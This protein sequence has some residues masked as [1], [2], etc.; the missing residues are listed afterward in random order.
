L[1]RPFTSTILLLVALLTAE[2]T[3]ARDASVDYEKAVQ[4][5]A[6]DK[7]DEAYINLKNALQEDP[8][9]LSARLLLAEVYFNSG[10]IAGAQRESEEALLLGAD[11]NLVLPIY[12]QSLILQEKVDQLFEI[13]RSADSFTPASQFEWALLKGQGYL[14]RNE[15]D[16]A[17]AQFEKATTILPE[18][19]RSDNTIAAIYLSRNMDAD[20]RKLVD[21]SL[22]LDPKN[23]KTWQLSGELEFKAK[24]YDQALKYFQRGYELDPEDLRIQRSLAQIYLQLG[25]RGK[26]EE[27]LKR[28][29]DVSPDDPAAT[30]ISAL[31]LIGDG[32]VEL[33]DSMLGNLSSMLSQ[34]DEGKR[35]S[36]ETMLFIRASAEYIQGNDASAIGLFNT[37]LLHN[38]GNIS[39]V[40]ILADLYLRNGDS[41]RATELLSSRVTEVSADLGLSIQLLNLYIKSGNT[42][43]A[44]ELLATLKN[45]GAGN[46]P[47][48]V[49]A[50]A[51]LL[52]LKGQPADALHLMDAQQFEGKLP[53]G[54]DLLRGVLQ[55]E[56]GKNAEAQHGVEQLIAA[57]PNIVRINNFAAA[58]YLALDKLPEANTYIDKALQ[59]EPKNVDARFNRAMWYKKSGELDN[60]TKTLK[61]L[62]E[63]QPSHTKALLL[64]ARIL[65]LQHKYDEAIDWSDKVYAYDKT[66]RTPGE[67]QIEIYSQAGNWE[68]AKEVAQRLVREDPLNTDY[69]VQLATIAMKTEDQELAQNTLSRLYPLWKRDPDKLRQLAEMQARFHN[70]VAARK[71]LLQALKLDKDDYL[72]QLDIARLDLAEGNYDTAQK[73]AEGLKHEFGERSDSSQV[74]GEIAFA[75]QQPDVARQHFLDAFRLNN[76]NTEA[77]IRLYELSAKGPG[78]KA[79]TDTMESTLKKASLPVV[80]VRLMADSYLSQGKTAKAAVYYEKLLGLE[81]LASDP[82]I[83]NNLANI[84]AKDDLAK[85]LTTAKKGLEASGEQSYALLD[86]VGW[87]LARQGENEQA[88]SYLRKSYTKNSTDPEIRYHLGAT[89]LALGRTAEAKKE[90]RAALDS[91]QQ[92][93]GRDDAEKL[94]ASATQ[95]ASASR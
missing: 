39:A 43:R 22:A 72:V 1:I 10:D 89:L 59:L 20:A 34:F 9:L 26:A 4:A 55:L 14:L 8:N 75:R 58:T 53:Q 92:F 12:G 48:L 29:L 51:E 62:V 67:L 73:L 32:D 86:T 18:S 94:M 45:K 60:A 80:A 76:D 36:D 13:E 16:L 79:F 82:A 7:Y 41:R 5:Y 90:L 81:S 88:L 28:I 52:R 64:M 56:L 25:D 47:Y 71:S 31:L 11:I 38:K 2:V 44:E 27:F 93:L 91:G 77:V 68:K 24:N 42:Y 54:Y 70:T 33:G 61:A 23:A 37:Y 85:A 84:Y 78:Q 66:S 21:K 65:F 17:R 3:F 50:E 63:D 19:V 95:S 6:E 35:Q 46:S 15:P 74:L 49:M 83:L 57:Y 69:L 40:R 87:I 30:L